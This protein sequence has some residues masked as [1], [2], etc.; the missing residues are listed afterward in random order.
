ME[1]YLKQYPSLNSLI[2]RFETWYQNLLNQEPSAIKLFGS[3]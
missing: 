1:K 3:F 2:L